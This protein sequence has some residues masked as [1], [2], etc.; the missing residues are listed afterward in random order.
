M[1]RSH[2]S[3]A[4]LGLAVSLFACRGSEVAPDPTP[5]PVEAATPAARLPLPLTDMLAL[6]GA[7]TNYMVLR[8]AQALR[9]AGI[10]WQALVLADPDNAAYAGFF[11]QLTKSLEGPDPPL[12][13]AGIDLRGGLVIS[14]V[15][16]AG[17]VFVL[18]SSDPPLTA[19]LLTTL[20][21]PRSEYT[22]CRGVP[23]VPSHVVCATDAADLP[24]HKTG[25][26]HARRAAL[27]ASLPG[28]DLDAATLF[29]AL[30][31]KDVAFAGELGVGRQTIHFAIADDST[32]RAVDAAL[33][34]GPATLLRFVQPNAGFVWAR[35]DAATLRLLAP[36]LLGADQA[37]AGLLADWNGEALLAGSDDPA[38]LQLRAGLNAT[39]SASQLI[40]LL[41]LDAA[42]ARPTELDSLPGAPIH[43]DADVVHI[44]DED[45]SVL[46]MWTEGKSKLAGLAAALGLT[47]RLSLFAA[48]GSLALIAGADP[49]QETRLGARWDPEMALRGFP[50][51]A[52]ADLRAGRMLLIAQAPLDA[53]HSPH[54]RAALEL[55]TP[56]VD[57]DVLREVRGAISELASLS[58]ITLWASETD[59]LVVWHLGL[60]NIGN[61][62]EPRG[63]AA[64]AAAADAPDAAS[65]AFAALAAAEP[66]PSLAA[67]YRDRAGSPGPVALTRSFLGALL[68]LGP[69]LMHLAEQA[70]AVPP[71]PPVPPAR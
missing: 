39:A 26:G 67:A 7:D 38:T 35:F 42:D 11:A 45:V 18:A 50:P 16:E 19:T 1:S 30:A 47:P 44:G 14:W 36:G 46:R 17:D 33:A 61:T 62:V 49:V 6:A 66:E 48:H 20:P 71:A 21:F 54:M 58:R 31:G 5:A 68:V 63:Q 59:G 37:F 27:A 4:S 3:A 53:L 64:L 65:V 32:A 40:G 55:V 41:A 34:P 8:D 23:G 2:R 43:R 70:D 9:D 60:V 15:P 12:R 22:T 10:P 25:D 69:A 24:H 52:L 57:A 28:V 29:G 13:R 51:A 56:L